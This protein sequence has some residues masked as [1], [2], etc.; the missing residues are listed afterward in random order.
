MLSARM[1]P[2]PLAVLYEDA[3]MIAVEKPAG[4]LVVP[5]RGDAGVKPLC[6]QLQA[7][8][9]RKPFV[10]HRLDRETSGV[11]VFAKDAEAHK[12]LCAQFEAR[13]VG[14]RYLAVV[15]GALETP[16][17]VDK[18]LRRF[19]S[20]RIGIDPRGKRAVTRY[21]P[22]EVHD[23]AT[24]IHAFPESGRQHQIRVHLFSIGHPIVGDPL[25]HKGP[26]DG[27]SRLLLHAERLKLTSPD[28]EALTIK[29]EP[30]EDFTAGYAAAKADKA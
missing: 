8:W 3:R 2:P 16:G 29:S 17:T 18:P 24:L 1:K 11:V 5:G 19:G 23:R 9:N 14:K 7:R 12:M 15:R 28:G 26:P 21:R 6:A 30:P 27:A 13:E 20:G 22:L 25:Y 10:V 4:V